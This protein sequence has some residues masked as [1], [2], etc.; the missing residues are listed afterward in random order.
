MINNYDMARFELIER[1]VNH[2]ALQDLLLE[3]EHDI[4]DESLDVITYGA[5]VP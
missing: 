5:D 3:L 1:I 4:T 2:L